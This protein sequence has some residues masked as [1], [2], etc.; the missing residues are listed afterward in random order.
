[1]GSDEGYDVA[2]VQ[3]M[4]VA[5][6]KHGFNAGAVCPSVAATKTGGRDRRIRWRRT[7]TLDQSINDFSEEIRA[8]P[9]RLPG[10]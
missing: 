4:Y 5:D 9:E 7:F 8:N 2:S 6:D 3:V 10:E 1:M